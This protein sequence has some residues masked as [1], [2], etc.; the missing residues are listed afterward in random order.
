MV[1]PVR[2]LA[3]VALVAWVASVVTVRMVL[4]A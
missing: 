2:E 1:V 4:L 3:T